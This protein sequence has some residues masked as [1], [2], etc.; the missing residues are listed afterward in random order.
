MLRKRKLCQCIDVNF[1][2][3][4]NKMTQMGM[5]EKQNREI[6]EEIAQPNEQKWF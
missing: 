3:N 2:H 5:K 6:F 1:H 4:E